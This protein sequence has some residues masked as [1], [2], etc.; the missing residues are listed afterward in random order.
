MRYE[1]KFHAL[2]V[3]GSFIQEFDYLLPLKVEQFISAF[4]E[5]GDEQLA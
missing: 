5:V 1:H 4:I 2:T 3:V